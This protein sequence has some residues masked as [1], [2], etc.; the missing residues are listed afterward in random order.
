MRNQGK[1]RARGGWQQ[2]SEAKARRMLAA[3]ARSGTSAS[4]FA[5]SRGITTRRIQY[6]SKRLIDEPSVEF[7][8]VPIPGPA[9]ALDARIEIAAGDI[10]VRLRE[11][12]D[13]EY[14]ARL[15]IAIGGRR[16]C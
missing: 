16:A 9:A 8:P 15:V 14:L 11:G 7:V 13:V 2:W 5:R 10:V 12:I 6:W 1:G 3:F 4:A